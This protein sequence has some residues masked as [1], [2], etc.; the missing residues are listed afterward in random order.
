MSWGE[1]SCLKPCRDI[2]HCEPSKCNCECPGYIW[3]GKTKPDSVM[4]KDYP[5]DSFFKKSS[6]Y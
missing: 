4:K 3:D 5:I 1:R 2:E 6:E